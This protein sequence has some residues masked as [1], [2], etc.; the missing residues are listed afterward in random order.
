MFFSTR[1]AF[2]A[3]AV[4]LLVTSVTAVPTTTNPSV[5]SELEARGCGIGGCKKEGPNSTP[6]LDTRG[7]GIGGCKKQDVND[8]TRSP[9][10]DTR[11]C[12]IGGCKKE[13]TGGSN[14]N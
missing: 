2:S 8:T 11:G 14:L 12:G 6:E 10:V 13:S 4:A 3:L 5:L 1:T 9:K 7:C